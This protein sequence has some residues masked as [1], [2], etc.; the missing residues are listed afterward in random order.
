MFKNILMQWTTNFLIV[1]EYIILILIIDC[2]DLVTMS[3]HANTSGLP[4][5][6]LPSLKT[7]F[8]FFWVDKS[9]A[10]SARTDQTL[11]C[12]NECDPSEGFGRPPVRLSW[13]SSLQKSTF[14]V[15]ALPF[16]WIRDWMKQDSKFKWAF[17]AFRTLPGSFKINLY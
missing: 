9:I 4:S 13:W 5:L 8:F 15:K 17:T 7:A 10:E 12:G 11:N 6:S 16:S 2:I 1:H 3:C 14:L